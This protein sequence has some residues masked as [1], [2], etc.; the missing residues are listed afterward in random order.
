MNP[1]HIALL[2]AAISNVSE[3]PNPREVDSWV[4]DTADILDAEQEAR[5]DT[6]IGALNAETSVEIAVVTVHDVDGTPKQFATA[7]FNHWGIGD[8]EL[9]NGLLIL[10]VTEQRRLEMETGTGLDALLPSDWLQDMQELRMV[11]HFRAGDYGA[12]IVAG[13]EEAANRIRYGPA[14]SQSGVPQPNSRQRRSPDRDRVPDDY[15]GSSGD[16]PW[17]PVGGGIFSLVFGTWFYRRWRWKKW[18]TCAQCRVPMAHL[19]EVTDDEHLDEGQKKEED[20]RSRNYHVFIC[21]QCQDTKVRRITRWLS[22]FSTCGQCSYRTSR[23]S[24][25]TLVHATYDHGGQVQITTNCSHCGHFN[26]RIRYTSKKTRPTST[27]SGSSSRGSRSRSSSRSSFGG[28][29]SRGGGAGS[30]W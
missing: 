26:E 2:V 1:I 24:S 10:L 28:G 19:D 4:S 27:S 14:E 13:L 5:L 20:L 15:S 8:A 23:T 3:V 22:G 11:P 30:S 16:T 25:T 18:S 6:L 7:L 9:N 17:V 29:R 21:P 12:G